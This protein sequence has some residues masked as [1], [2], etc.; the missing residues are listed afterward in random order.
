MI[1][2]GVISDV[3]DDA[4]FDKLSKNSCYLE[5]SIRNWPK[6]YTAFHTLPLELEIQIE[7]FST[8]NENS[9]SI[10][11]IIPLLSA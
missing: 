9:N 10:I 5:F 11:C 7:C 6:I 4:I 2:D 8:L 1:I 3:I